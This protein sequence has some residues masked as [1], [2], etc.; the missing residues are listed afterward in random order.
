M[1]RIGCQEKWVHFE[2]FLL[3]VEETPT[4]ADRRGGVSTTHKK[5]NK[6]ERIVCYEKLQ[7]NSPTV[8]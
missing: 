6:M 3:V 8:R 4:R 1:E 7:Y 5:V 2:K